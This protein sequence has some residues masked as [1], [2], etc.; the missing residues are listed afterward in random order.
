M[1]MMA[2]PVVITRIAKLE[3]IDADSTAMETA[4]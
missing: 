2:P 1:E 4:E 3:V